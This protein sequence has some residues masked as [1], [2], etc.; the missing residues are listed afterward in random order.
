MVNLDEISSAEMCARV[1]NLGFS[2]GQYIQMYGERW[3]VLSDPF[4]LDGGIAVNVK[5]KGG[6]GSRVIKLPATVLQSVKKNNRA[7][8]SA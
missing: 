6:A 7:P 4:P 2:P 8:T 5:V 3:E 1:K